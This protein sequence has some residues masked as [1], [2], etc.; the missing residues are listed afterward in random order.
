MQLEIAKVPL[1]DN[2]IAR[3]IHMLAD[4]E[5][6][7]LEKIHISEKLALQLDGSTDISGHAQLL[8]NVWLE[9]EDI[10]RENFLF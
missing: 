6:N 8:A 3:H 10:I 7:V 2:T 4:I 9:G 1:S 5:K